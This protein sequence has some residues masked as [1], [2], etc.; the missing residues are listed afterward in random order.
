MKRLIGKNI[1]SEF[2]DSRDPGSD[3]IEVFKN[4]N[5]T[6]VDKV[7]NSNAYKS[8]NGLITPQTDILI[9]R[10]DILFDQLNIGSINVSSGLQFSFFPNWIFNANSQYDF[11]KTYN[12]L[13][14]KRA[15]LIVIG[16]FTRT[17]IITGT[18]DTDHTGDF[19][20]NNWTEMDDYY[21]KNYTEI[22][23]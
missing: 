12:I 20:F 15:N 16:D 19:A 10:G 23:E 3:F 7:R 14:M 13:N 17:I 18:T 6:D 5:N 1:Q 8:L 22:I 11:L 9:W 21:A 4:P 2:Y